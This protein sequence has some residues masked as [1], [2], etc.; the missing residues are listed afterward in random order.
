MYICQTRVYLD[1]SSAAEQ[2][3]LP[4][5]SELSK[6]TDGLAVRFYVVTMLIGN[7]QKSMRM[8][9]FYMLHFSHF[10]ALA[11]QVSPLG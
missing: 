1:K 10:P 9:T 3:I 11:V 2:R 5:D 7:S 8:Y 4:I 6:K